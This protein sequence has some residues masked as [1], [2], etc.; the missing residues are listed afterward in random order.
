MQMH[1]Y[2]RRDA[3][4]GKFKTCEMYDL[5]ANLMDSEI[6]FEEFSWKK[7]WRKAISTKVF[8]FSWKTFRERILIRDNLLKHGVSDELIFGL[9]SMCATIP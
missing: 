7:L 9:C 5:L 8:S 4:D 1:I 6:C 3:K 2:N